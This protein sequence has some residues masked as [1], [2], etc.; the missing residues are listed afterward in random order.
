M[1]ISNQKHRGLK[2]ADVD[3]KCGAAYVIRSIKFKSKLNFNPQKK[4]NIMEKGKLYELLVGRARVHN[5]VFAS[6]LD[7]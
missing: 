4:V 6:L 5:Y 1:T 7:L 2:F 3:C